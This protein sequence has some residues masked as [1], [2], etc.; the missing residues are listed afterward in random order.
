MAWSCSEF[1][2]DFLN[3]GTKHRTVDILTFD[4]DFWW[5][6]AMQFISANN[7]VT[8]FLLSIISEILAAAMLV[9]KF[10]HGTHFRSP[11]IIVLAASLY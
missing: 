10:I 7:R 8:S 6:V 2:Y 5:C 9:L 11:Y 3:K 4:F 1:R